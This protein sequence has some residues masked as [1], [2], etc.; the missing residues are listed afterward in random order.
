MNIINKL[1]YF[2]KRI[3]S[4]QKM[5]DSPCYEKSFVKNNSKEE[6]LDSIQKDIKTNL[7]K[8]QILND[9]DK[10]PDLINHLSYTRLVQLNQLYVDRISE[11]NIEIQTLK[12]KINN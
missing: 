3:F 4:S 1:K 11:I 2:L 10:N 7:N 12:N 6:F 5:I 9:I 8:K